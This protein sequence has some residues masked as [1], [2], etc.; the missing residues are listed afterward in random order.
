MGLEAL[1]VQVRVPEALDLL[2]DLGVDPVIVGQH[3]VGLGGHLVEVV[4]HPL[5]VALQLLVG[6]A[7]QVRL[8]IGGDAADGFLDAVEIIVEVPL[9][10][11]TKQQQKL[12]GLSML[13][14]AYKDHA[15]DRDGREGQ[16]DHEDRHDRDFRSE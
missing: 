3:A 12:V 13:V 6:E 10:R 8:H 7:V 14:F 5:H 2:R 11:L 16:D 4:P 1:A 15:E 9:A